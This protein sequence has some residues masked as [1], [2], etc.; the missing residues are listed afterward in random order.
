[1]AR[2]YVYFPKEVSVGALASLGSERTTR[3]LSRKVRVRCVSLAWSAYVC[4]RG[5]P[6]L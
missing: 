1:M 3:F 2:K 6:G 4:E 5:A